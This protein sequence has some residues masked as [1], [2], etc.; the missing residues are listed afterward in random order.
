LFIYSATT[1]IISASLMTAWGLM[2]KMLSNQCSY[3]MLHPVNIKISDCLWTAKPSHY[4][5]LRSTQVFH[6]SE[7]GKSALLGLRHSSVLG[8]R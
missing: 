4:I 6:P 8:D 2:V 5:P 7:V 3:P 1:G